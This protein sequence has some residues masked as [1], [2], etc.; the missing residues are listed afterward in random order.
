MEYHGMVPVHNLECPP[1]TRFQFQGSNQDWNRYIGTMIISKSGLTRTTRT[2][3]DAITRRY[4]YSLKHRE[5]PYR[6]TIVQDPK[7]LSKETE[8]RI[9]FLSFLEQATCH[10][11]GLSLEE[12][13]GLL[14]SLRAIVPEKEDMVEEQ[15]KFTNQKGR[16]LKKVDKKKLNL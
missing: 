9:D 13:Y 3:M 6:R 10:F 1:H 15:T 2:Q 14:D 8:L 4:N 11:N 12:K 5:Y 16:L 7:P